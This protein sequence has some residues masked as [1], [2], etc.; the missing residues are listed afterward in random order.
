MLKPNT[1][2]DHELTALKIQ[3]VD[4]TTQYITSLNR[5]HAYGTDQPA[6]PL[7]YH[8]IKAN[9][10]QKLNFIN[11]TPRVVEIRDTAIS[12]ILK[13]APNTTLI[14]QGN[15]KK[16]NLF[17]N[18]YTAFLNLANTATPE[19][20]KDPRLPLQYYHQEVDIHDIEH[21]ELVNQTNHDAFVF[22]CKVTE[23]QRCAPSQ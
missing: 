11:D 7:I 20:T 21:L 14:V 23:T 8:I 6:L 12:W 4:S 16:V 9:E 18:C 15:Q 5:K 13:V 17:G 22:L 1:L 2:I 19:N 10:R 3:H